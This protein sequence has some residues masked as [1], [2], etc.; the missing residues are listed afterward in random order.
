MEQ[1][2]DK[3]GM[4]SIQSN[5]VPD[6]AMGGIQ[7]NLPQDQSV[8]IIKVIGV[9]GGG[10]NAVRNMWLEGITNVTFAVCNT[11]SQQ[12]VRCPVPVKLQLG[13]DGLGAGGN[14]DKGRAEAEHTKERIRTLLDD[15]TKMVFVT[16]SMGGGTGT[17]AGPIVAKVAK[18]MGILTIG[19]V[20]IP[21]AFEG[22]QKIMKALKGM[23]EMREQV[24]ALLVV[25]NDKLTGGTT[26]EVDGKVQRIAMKER[27]KEADDILKDA[28]KSISELITLHTDGDIN[29]DFRDVETTMKDGGDAIMAAGRASG[30]HRVERAIVQALDSPLLYGNDIGRAQ[31]IL[32]DIYTSDEEPLYIDEMKEIEDFMQQLDPQIEVIWGTSTDNT[33]GKDVKVIILAAGMA[34][35]MKQEPK[36]EPVVKDREYYLNLIQQLYKKKTDG[37]MQKTLFSEDDLDDDGVKGGHNDAHENEQESKG[38]EGATEVCDEKGTDETSEAGDLIVNDE[39]ITKQTPAPSKPFRTFLERAKEWL[40]NLT[41][42]AE[43]A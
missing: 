23:E 41:R 9:G 39:E 38:D 14:P 3:T 36:P 25:Q 19:I 33:L 10:C 42:E 6:D 16:A 43:Q 22:E 15:G 4:R 32:F 5:T 34:Q 17:G 40:M 13:D 24:D 31:R 1:I 18:E 30:D 37:M 12:L 8:G 29:L 35:Q 7:F 21:F 28:A 27:F 11:D 26:R 20:T 2:F